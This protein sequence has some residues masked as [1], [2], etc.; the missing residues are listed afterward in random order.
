MAIASNA[1]VTVNVNARS[2][3][4]DAL[5]TPYVCTAAAD[6]TFADLRA[7]LLEDD[8]IKADE[9]YVFL[10]PDGKIVGKSSEAHLKWSTALKVRL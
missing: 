1:P 6:G 3:T 5:G 9:K 8:I 2:S 10:L 7:V 4:A